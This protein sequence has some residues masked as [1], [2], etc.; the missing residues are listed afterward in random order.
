MGGDSGEM[1]RD[2]EGVEFKQMKGMLLSKLCFKSAWTKGSRR[3]RGLYIKVWINLWGACS[4]KRS[5][6]SKKVKKGKR[7]KKYKNEKNK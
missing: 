4:R 7:S 2:G 1:R 3:R 6:I 5:E